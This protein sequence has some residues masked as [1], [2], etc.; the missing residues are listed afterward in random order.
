M[1]R[2]EYIFQTAADFLWK[3]WMLVMLLGLGIFYTVMTGFI[4]FRFFPYT[5]R[6]FVKE[7]R[8]RKNTS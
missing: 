2:T 8:N 5:V 7:I 1:S 4:Q 3:D 6:F